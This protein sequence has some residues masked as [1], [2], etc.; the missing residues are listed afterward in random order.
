MPLVPVLVN[1]E[2]NGVRLDT[3][4][5]KQS[6]EHFTTRLQSIEKE[7]YTLAEGEFNI[8]S[9]KQVGE[10]LFDKLKIVE[11]AKKQKPD[12]TSPQKKYWRACEIST[13]SS[14]RFWNT[15][16]LRNY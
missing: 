11:K 3:E 15:G 1:I 12:S 2:S 5:L 6:S 16:D 8:A 9:P 7:I 10:I 4:A 13:I 14:V